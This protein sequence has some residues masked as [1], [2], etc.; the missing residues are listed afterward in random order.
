[1]YYRCSYSIGK[2]EKH[3]LTSKC[4]CCVSN[5]CIA[6]SYDNGITF[7]RKI[8]DKKN[9]ILFNKKC[10][11]HN[12]TVF[13]DKNNSL[14]GI[15]GLHTWPNFHTVCYKNE[16][17]INFN[18]KNIADPRE[19]HP[20][21]C[22]GIH[23]LKSHNIFEWD[24]IQKTP[25]ISG[26]HK[27]Q[28]D[29]RNGWGW[30]EF[31]GMSTCLYS[32]VL[33]KYFIYC[34]SNIRNGIR[35]I[36]YTTSNDLINWDKFK[37]IN[38]DPKLNVNN[39]ENYYYLNVVED[40]ESKTFLGFSPYNNSNISYI[41]LLY[42]NNGSDWKKISNILDSTVSNK[43]S[44][45]QNANNFILSSDNKEYYFYI[46]ENYFSLTDT[47]SLPRLVR[48]SIRKDGFCSVFSNN[49]YVKINIGK[50]SKIK[51]NYKTYENGYIVIEDIEFKNS[52][53][54]VNIKLEGDEID[55]SVDLYENNYSNKNTNNKILKI[56]IINSEI[57]TVTI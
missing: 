29:N 5:T 38:I 54:K 27:G 33:N 53:E 49:G 48:Y 2:E 14:M 35:S 47:K 22:N 31:D 4:S 56:K 10:I 41:T 6:I 7:Q 34:R 18:G 30:S 39:L 24:N 42:S 11:S 37:L 51:I 40:F 46:N 28:T 50:S 12:F 15:G 8:N 36:Q 1:M 19:Y 17:T 16:K 25:I 3:G 45:S 20:C 43:R 55:K 9:N 57:F 26:L 44:S 23:L 32:K 13:K 52:I 21:Y